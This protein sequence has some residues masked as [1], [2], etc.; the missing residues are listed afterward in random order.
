FA[1][2]ARRI[3]V[4]GVGLWQLDDGT[5]VLQRHGIDQFARADQIDHHANLSAVADAGCDRV[6]G[7]GSS[8]SLRAD[9]PVGTVVAI[10]D[11]YAP[12][13]TSTRRVGRDAHAVHHVHAG[14]RAVVVAAWQA[15]TTTPLRDGGTYAHTTGPRFETPAEVRA[16]AMV[17]DLVGMTL[18]GEI[19]AA[20]ELGLAYAGIAVVDN[21]ANGVADESLTAEAFYAQLAD[22]T[23]RLLA[24]LDALL[25]H[26]TDPEVSWA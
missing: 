10:D 2:D 7:L 4:A 5:V 6:L 19:I 1:A 16:L 17:A 24:D 13:V 14:W 3:D 15:A 12:Q 20:S 23:P 21:L 25:P 26:L 18:A 8:G 9:W 11:F 22:N